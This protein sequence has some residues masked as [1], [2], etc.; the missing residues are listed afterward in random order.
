MKTLPQAVLSSPSDSHDPQD[1]FV[2]WKV[3][4]KSNGQE[5][6][7]EEKIYNRYYHLFRQGELRDLVIEAAKELN[8]ETSLKV[9]AKEGWEQGNWNI[10]AT[11]VT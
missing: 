3:L 4:P 9:D 2:P 10:Q 11:F 8:V 5:E 1:V 7:K 6:E